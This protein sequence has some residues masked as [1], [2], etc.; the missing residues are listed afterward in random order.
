MRQVDRHGEADASDVGLHWATVGGFF[1][2]LR[3]SFDAEHL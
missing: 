3:C 2:L 1:T